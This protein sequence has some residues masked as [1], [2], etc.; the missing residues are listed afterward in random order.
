MGADHCVSSR[1]ADAIRSM[2]GS[3]DLLIVTVNVSL[4][5]DAL[6]STLAPKGRLHVVGAVLEP[7]PIQAMSLIMGQRSVSG[8]PTG[9]PV[10]I[11]K[12]LEFAARHGVTPQ[13]E[14]FPMSRVNEALERLKAGK[15]R[16]RGVLDADF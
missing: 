3:L 1:D 9:S 5:W 2:A 15:M 12:M 14:R 6:I 13:T 16:Y 7:I 4:D 8:S 10:A 11:A